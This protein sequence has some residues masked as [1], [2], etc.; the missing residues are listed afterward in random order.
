MAREL[1]ANT[2]R[3][4]SSESLTFRIAKDNANKLRAEALKK[5]IS[6]NSFVNEILKSYF[7]WY[8][9]EP[10]IGFVSILK[11]V[12]KEVFTKM[13]KEQIAEIAENTA[14]QETENCIYFMK[15]KMDLDCFLSW[16]ENRMKNSSIQLS[17]T[18]DYS[19]KIQTY[20]IKHDICENWS[21]YL[22][23][24]IE[25]IFNDVLQK[26]VEISTSFSMLTFRYKED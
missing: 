6:I 22:K 25:H 7:E 2:L 5:G 14:N 16:L 10:N 13:S 26:N 24:I 4:R 17:H 12:V 3:E 19:S 9:F 8:I 11:P 15:G 20:V 1:L 18:F 21:L 23:E